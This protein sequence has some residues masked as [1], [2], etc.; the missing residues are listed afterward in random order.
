[1]PVTSAQ[2]LDAYKTA[3]QVAS[4]RYDNIYRSAWTIFSYM[5]AV[6][7][8]VLSFGG[9]HFYGELLVLVSSM[10]LVFWY[11]TTYLP[12]NGYGDNTLEN[13]RALEER[14]SKEFDVAVD[15]FAE[16]DRSRNSRVFRAR[17]PI[18]FFMSVILVV[19]FVALVL[20]ICK[21]ARGEK[22]L[23]PNESVNKV[24]LV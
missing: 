10:P 11:L 19:A 22:L 23:K 2:K 21:V 20:V 7:A 14:I 12:L 15:H 17:Y 1:M 8:A 5:T 24:Q 4:T 16:F 9:S 13:L 3:Y 6:S 18:H